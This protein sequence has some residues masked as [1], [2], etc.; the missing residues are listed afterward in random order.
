MDVKID[1]L[2]G[3]ERH[4]F[5]L[6]FIDTTLRGCGQ[7]M[8]QNN[9]LTGAF[10]SAVFFLMDPVQTLYT[11]LCKCLFSE[12]TLQ[13]ITELD[14]KAAHCHTLVPQRHGPFL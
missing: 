14:N 6:E 11:I 12:V 1:K 10:S 13:T 9:S 5:L 7:V 4:S 2:L 3:D 8:F